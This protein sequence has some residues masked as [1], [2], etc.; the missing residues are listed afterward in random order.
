MNTTDQPRRFGLRDLADVPL[1]AKAEEYLQRATGSAQG[2][3]AWR[4]RKLAEA[5][6]LFAL[7]QIAPRLEVAMVGL[8]TALHA[9]LHLAVS[10]PCLPEP[11][12]DLVVEES[13]TLAL[14]YP[15]E[16]M[17]RRLPGTAFVQ[18]LNPLGVWHPNIGIGDQRICLGAEL[19][20]G[21][22]TTEILL[23][24]YGA[25]T[26][27]NIQLDERDPS[28]VLNKA[29]CEFWQA[30]LDRVPLSSEPFLPRLEV[31]P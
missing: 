1:E 15:E 12:S 20:P 5:R 17:R 16:A 3:P 28:G 2:S 6:D 10:V 23:L 8:E 24:S 26:L 19:G 7:A 29:A 31:N 14:V 21:L 22:K 18:V 30:N 27:T 11:G 4:G 9:I 25:L 13:A